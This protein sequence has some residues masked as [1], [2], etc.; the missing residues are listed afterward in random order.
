MTTYLIQVSLA[1]ILFYVGYRLCLKQET[2]FAF[3]RGYLLLALLASV[4]TPLINFRVII[5]RF[6]A[7]PTEPAFEAT[8]LPEVT[9]Q[10]IQTV[11]EPSQHWALTAIS[12]TYWIGFSAAAI[13]LIISILK[14]KRLVAAA[15]PIQDQNG[16]Y[17]LL[18]NSSTSFSFLHYV[19]LG[20]STSFTE[21][22]KQTILAHERAHAHLGHSLDVLF[23]RAVGV[24]VWFN[25]II[26]WYKKELETIHEFQADAFT[27]KPES[28]NEYCQLLVRETLEGQHISLANHFNKSLTLKRIQM[29]QSIKKN[30]SRPRIIGLG[31]L[32]LLVFAIFSCEE[33]VMT[34]FKNAAK[35]S[36]LVTEYPDF[37]KQTVDKI[38]AMDPNSEP[39]VYGLVK[40]SDM[41]KFVEDENQ[42]ITYVTVTDDPDFA[43]YVILGYKQA[44]QAAGYL[45]EKRGNDNV[46]T[47]VEEQAHP[48][49]GMTDFY[50]FI[51]QNIQY[52]IEARKLNIEGRVF[53]SF[54]VDENGKLSDFKIIRGIGSG[55]DE[56]AVRVLMLSPNWK[57][58]M[59][60]GVA[61]KSLFNMAIVFKLGQNQIQANSQ[62]SD[63]LEVQGAVLPETVVV[64]HN[65]EMQVLV[66]QKLIDGR[67]VLSGRVTKKEDSNPLPGVHIYFKNRTEGT[68]TDTNGTFN[69]ESPINSGSL[70]FSFVGFGTKEWK[71]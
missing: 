19:F 29:I 57:P 8:W 62:K 53:V 43:A 45:T 5:A 7:I 65:Q 21:E 25:P 35:Q 64:A 41:Q 59:Q 56:E 55:C 15:K 26:H 52:P 24:M 14:L 54:M 50:K 44:K 69:L 32:V 49:N 67:V 42:A 46:F 70:V 16:W 10:A 37:V 17:Y 48:I 20:N 51:G 66:D 2:N 34:D 1:L 38:K 30:M 9:V 47:I 61:V 11:V 18:E 58:G 13:I 28:S 63:V 3:L 33:K 31:V 68:T 40:T 23:I 22:E 6:T 4:V 36:M 60:D 12:L 71:F 27:V 39:R